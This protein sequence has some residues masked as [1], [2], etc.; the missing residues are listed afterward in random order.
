MT[1]QGSVVEVGSFVFAHCLC[2]SMF[3]VACCFVVVVV[4][5]GLCVCFVHWIRRSMRSQRG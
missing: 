5:V 2:L 1:E 4:L 3:V